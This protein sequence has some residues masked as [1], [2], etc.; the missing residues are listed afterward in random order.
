MEDSKKLLLLCIAHET[1]L[2]SK[3]GTEALTHKVARV[4]LL[5]SNFEEY[6][7]KPEFYGKLDELCIKELGYAIRM[8]DYSRTDKPQYGPKKLGLW[9]NR[10]VVTVNIDGV[11]VAVSDD[12]DDFSLIAAIK[13]GHLAFEG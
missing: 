9:I 4:F 3:E 5:D 13:G 1:V 10:V 8:D 7:P 12:E 6:D 11:P 2:E